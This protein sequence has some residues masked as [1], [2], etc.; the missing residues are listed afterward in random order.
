MDVRDTNRFRLRPREYL[1]ALCAVL[2]STGVARAQASFSGV[3]DLAGGS[4]S[5][6]AWAVSAHRAVV[7]GH[8]F[9]TSGFEAFR[10]R[11]ANGMLGLGDLPGGRFESA[12]YAVSANGLVIVGGGE[13]AS[14]S[15]A[16]RWT[17]TE[18]MV[19]LGDLPGGPFE[20]IARGLSADGFVVVG[21]GHTALGNEAFRWTP[22]GQMTGLGHLPGG[23]ANSQAR[24]VTPD[25]L[26]VVGSSDSGSGDNEAFRWI[27][28]T[29][30]RGLGDLPGGVF[31]SFALAVSSD[32][33]IVVGQGHNAA[34]RREAF[35]WSA[36][37][38][39]VGLGDFPGGSFD[40][41]AY[42]V[43]G[44][45]SV[46]VGSGNSASGFEAF[47]WDDENG[48]RSLRDVLVS[49]Y[50]LDLTGWEL[51]VATGTSSHGCAI[52]GYGRNPAGVLE[53]WIARIPVDTDGDGL[54]D[55]WETDGIPY[56]DEGGAEQRFMLPGADPLH[57]D[58][59]VEVDAMESFSLSS[60]AVALL[61]T[62][63][64]GAPLSNPDGSDGITLHVLR[65]ETDLPHVAVWQTDG[66]WPLDFD[67]WRFNSYGTW[68]ERNDPD[69]VALLEA[70]AMAYRYCIV[71]DGAAPRNILGCSEG[72]PA[73]NFV[74]FVGSSFFNTDHDE[75]L[76]AVFMH[77]LGHNL[78][79][80]HGGGDDINGKPNYPSIMNYVLTVQYSWAK[81]WAFWKLDYS[82]EGAG[83]FASLDESSLNERAGIGTPSGY[84]SNFKMP[85]GVNEL[86]RGNIVRR[87]KYVTLDYS[88]TDF[89]DTAGTMFQD[90]NFDISVRQDLNY[91][92]NDPGAPGMPNTASFPQPPHDPYDDWAHV[93]LALV[94]ATGAPAS[95]PPTDE[96]TIEA[97]E[98]IDANFPPPPGCAFLCGDASCD[99]TFNGGDIDPFFQA[100]GDPAAWQAAHPGCDLL[101]VTDVN[102]DGQLNGGDIDPFFVALGGGGC[103]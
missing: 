103:P 46:V 39:M 22:T 21:E 28:G 76:A 84:Y 83:K 75:R 69:H 58:L 80:R 62:A 33:S 34:S 4:D 7:V 97:L 66:C 9:S 19:G 82:R 63:F 50:E 65:D 12:A 38:G 90:G 31:R 32:G 86:D 96:L 8:S 16:F 101:C 49:E 91:A 98:W 51:W 30:M 78:G 13:S 77:E 27:A 56:I 36:G 44:D 25:G 52:V 57:Q 72:I 2:A 26:L 68:D 88:W 17:V 11:T 18:G 43:T 67:N 95:G 85:F 47:I 89:G 6:L 79:L 14:G 42:G 70:K 81:P 40:S 3:G 15:E 24:A 60:A 99:G 48:L 10:W 23:G 92:V 53:G 45:G 71:A 54:L 74:I 37:G 87:I 5:S 59:Y 20:S 1:I 55:C 29:G 93:S 73:D 102:G 61:E 41:T 94:A 100:L 35:R 64:A